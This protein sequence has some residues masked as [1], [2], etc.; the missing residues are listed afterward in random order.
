MKKE[1]EAEYAIFK[2]GEIWDDGILTEEDLN[3]LL[4]KRRNEYPNA[5][6]TFDLLTNA[7]RMMY[8]D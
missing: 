6:L 8:Y 1:V 4:E 5:E 7:E 2:D 3:D